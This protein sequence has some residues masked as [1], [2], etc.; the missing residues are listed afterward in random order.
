[1]TLVETR[2]QEE[3]DRLDMELAAKVAAATYLQLKS[4]VEQ[5]MVTMKEWRAALGDQAAEAALDNKYLKERQKTLGIYRLLKKLE[6]TS[7]Q[8]LKTLL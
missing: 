6:K 4:K 8:K 5:D 7:F 2:Q 1:M 3:L